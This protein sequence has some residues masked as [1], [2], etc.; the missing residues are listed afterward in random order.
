MHLGSDGMYAE[1]DVRWPF[2]V[3]NRTKSEISEREVPAEPVL[4]LFPGRNTNF[5]NSFGFF[6]H[7]LHEHVPWF[8]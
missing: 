6:P 1:V 4:V 8:L 2:L 7:F 5:H 3:R